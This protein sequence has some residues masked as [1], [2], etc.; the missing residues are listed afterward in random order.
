MIVQSAPEPAEGG[1]QPDQ[2]T[3]QHGSRGEVGAQSSQT[4]RCVTAKGQSWKQ[5]QKGRGRFGA[6]FVLQQELTAGFWGQGSSG[7]P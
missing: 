4:C 7:A 6:L 3:A 1:L 2:S 5:E